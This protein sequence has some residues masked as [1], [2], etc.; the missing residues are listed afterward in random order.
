[1]AALFVYERITRKTV[2]V[3]VVVG[4]IL[5]F[6]LVAF[7]MAWRDKH[8]ELLTA[9]KALAEKTQELADERQKSQ[10]ELSGF[11]DEIAMGHPPDGSNQT[12]V[13]LKVSVR[14][15]G[16][17]S[18][19]EAW[20][21]NVEVPGKGNF[22]C[23]IMHSDTAFTLMRS[24]GGPP[25]VYTPGETIYDKTASPVEHN[26]MKRGILAST[27][28][29]LKQE[30]VWQAG[31]VIR[32]TFEDINGKVIPFERTMTA[33]KNQPMYYPGVKP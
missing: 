25:M 12:A 32:V 22:H 3:R 5:A 19:A 11:I 6:I 16:A 13:F 9:Q 27:L 1:M 2:S 29:G 24:D 31:T 10:P 14:N 30:E 21:V 28:Q 8:R 26:G 33:E 20:T 23:Q 17:P 15:K 7:F 4:G 18:V